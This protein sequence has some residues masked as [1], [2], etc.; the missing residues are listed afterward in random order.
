MRG[1]V[2]AVARNLFDHEIFADEA[3]TE[4]EAWI[5]IVKEAA[6]KPTR[7][8]VGRHLVDLA[9]GQCAFTTRFMAVKFKWSEAKVRRFLSKLKSDAMLTIDTTQQVT[10]LTICNY[11]DYQ[12]VA[13]PRDA[14]TGAVTDEEPTHSRRKEENT[15]NIE[16]NK[17]PSGNG[18]VPLVEDQPSLE[19]QAYDLG[20][21][22]LGK[23][24]GGVITRLK[25]HHRGDWSEVMATLRLAA[26]K[27]SPA[28]WVGAILA[29]KRDAAWEQREAEIYAG[30]H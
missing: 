29:G 18:G 4:R 24:A 6:W 1:G 16:N 25:K 28:E 15:E 13:L 11:N 21:S 2:F 26:E 19:K 7:V 10:R 3:F 20:K 9:R 8:R 22:V 12:K 17:Y 30:V 5:W 14:K 23:S 27:S